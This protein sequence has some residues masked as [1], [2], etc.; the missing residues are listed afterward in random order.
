MINKKLE[1]KKVQVELMRVEAARCEMELRIEERLEEMS[2]L[3][4]HIVIQVAKEEELKQK[5]KE[6]GQ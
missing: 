3:K 1:L 2:R 5:I 6:I 4:E